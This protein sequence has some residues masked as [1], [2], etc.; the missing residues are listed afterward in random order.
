MTALGAYSK[1]VHEIA[2]RTFAYL[3]PDGSWGYSNAGLVVG[4]GSTLLVDTLFSIELTAEMLADLRREVQ[5]LDSIEWLVNTHANGDHC[6]GNELVHGSTIVSSRSTAED[7]SHDDPAILQGA[8]DNA[9]T[10]GEV[11]SYFRH[12]FGSFDFNGVHITAPTLTFDGSL[13]LD[14]GG[15]LV[16]L[17]ELGPAH[18]SGDVVVHVPDVEVLYAGD[19]LFIG[20]T[21]IVWVGPI[22]H[23]IDACDAMVAL[24]P[25]VVVPGHGPICDSAG[26]IQVRDYLEFVL[27]QSSRRL[28]RGMDP[29]DAALDIELGSFSS[30][31][32]FERISVNVAMAYHEL[33]ATH[34]PAVSAIEGFTSMSR[35]LARNG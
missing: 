6:Y 32:D 29:W 11:G 35:Y 2:P 31:L 3:Q 8:L 9:E 4:N 26:I 22:A 24:N 1:G 10:L 15:R 21:P 17:I 25:K 28:A 20:G 27:E 18:T 34:W 14:V 13:S 16:E 12:C 23:W 5:G 33:D 30:W 19:L 7:I